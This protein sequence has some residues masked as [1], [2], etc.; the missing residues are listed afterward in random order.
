MQNETTGSYSAETTLLNGVPIE[1]SK[2][3]YKDSS[4]NNKKGISGST[5]KLIAIISMFIDHL[6]AAVL[7]RIIAQGNSAGFNSMSPFCQ[8]LYD[9]FDLYT[10][11]EVMRYIGRLGFPIFCF[12]L[13][14]GF[15]H[16]HNVK[17][18]ALRLL[19][20]CAV[21]EIPFDLAF[22][23]TILEFTSQNVF[24]TL[25]IGL[26]V[27]IAFRAI[28]QQYAWAPVLRGMLY[29][30]ALFAGMALA[31]FLSTDYSY[32]GVFCITMLYITR[33]KKPLQ[34]VVGCIEFLWEL[35]APLAFIPIAFYNGKRGW[36]IKYFFYIFYPAHL[37]LLYLLAYALGLG[38]V[39]VF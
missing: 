24:F 36:N 10:I 20:F 18:Y 8:Y 17:K 7:I 4:N 16:T 21:S 1:P 12:L 33:K 39:T 27:M 22:Q 3:N 14:E 31:T 15:E 26:L 38:N 28:E 35:T 30:I 19:A 32:I 13:I 25:L 6:A 2:S 11:Y 23:N 29:I 37:L 5:I 9:N 34:I